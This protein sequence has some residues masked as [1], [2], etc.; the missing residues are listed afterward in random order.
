MLSMFRAWCRCDAPWR[1][2]RWRRGSVR[3]EPHLF[4]EDDRALREDRERS[5]CP[6]AFTAPRARKGRRVCVSRLA[7]ATVVVSFGCRS[8]PRGR[9]VTGVPRLNGDLE[10]A[11]L[12][13]GRGPAHASTPL[14]RTSPGWSL[15]STVRRLSISLA[16]QGRVLEADLEPERASDIA[17]FLASANRCLRF[18]GTAWQV[19]RARS[20]P[21]G[22]SS[23]VELDVTG[24]V[25][26]V[27]GEHRHSPRELHES[28]P[29]TRSADEVTSIRVNPVAPAV[30]L[31]CRASTGTRRRSRPSPRPA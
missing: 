27:L 18:S 10:S 5:G 9:C 11:D 13:I 17:R 31:A 24:D 2:E 3:A 14:T 12:A 21:P 15:V 28:L 23:E 1:S 16:E 6:L 4:S 19:L 29:F 22:K 20:G 26:V 7:L 25:D 30:S 8:S